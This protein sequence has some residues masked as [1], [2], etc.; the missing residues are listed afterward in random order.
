M[1]IREKLEIIRQ[2]EAR[3]DARIKEHS[4]AVSLDANNG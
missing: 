2:A 3:N 4:Q 1:S